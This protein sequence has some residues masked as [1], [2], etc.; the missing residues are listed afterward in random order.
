[1]SARSLTLTKVLR[2]PRRSAPIVF[3]I[4]TPFGALLLPFPKKVSN[5]SVAPLWGSQRRFESAPPAL[6]TDC[7]APIYEYKR[8]GPAHGVFLGQKKKLINYL[9]WQPTVHGS[10][11]RSPT[12]PD[13]IVHFKSEAESKVIFLQT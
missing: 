1:M 4:D 7:M 2:S 3:A 5:F 8:R 6:R 9:K 13:V 12:K 11:C 10:L